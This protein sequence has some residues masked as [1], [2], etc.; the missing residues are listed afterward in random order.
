MVLVWCRGYGEGLLEK[1]LILK[2]RA[3]IKGIC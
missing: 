2:K 1:E 3:V